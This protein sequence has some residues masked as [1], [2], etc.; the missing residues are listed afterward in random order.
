MYGVTTEG[1]NAPLIPMSRAQIE[2][3]AAVS[4]SRRARNEPPSRTVGGGNPF[5]SGPEEEVGNA[6]NKAQPPPSEESQSHC[7]T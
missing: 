3:M 7:I 4:S 5:D 2:A 6:D 1:H